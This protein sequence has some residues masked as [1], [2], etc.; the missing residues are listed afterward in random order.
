MDELSYSLKQD[1]TLTHSIGG[2][3][4][5]TQDNPALRHTSV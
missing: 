1:S 2:V 4:K 3:S 5:Q